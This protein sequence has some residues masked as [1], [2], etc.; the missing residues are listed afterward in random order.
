MQFK[1]QRGHHMSS[2]FKFDQYGRMQEEWE[3]PLDKADANADAENLW[4][5]SVR[6]SVEDIFNDSDNEECS[7]EDMALIGD[8]VDMQDPDDVGI[9]QKFQ[10]AGWEHVQYYGA[11]Q[12]YDQMLD[13]IAEIIETYNLETPLVALRRSCIS[14]S[15]VVMVY[16]ENGVQFHIDTR[17]HGDF[18]LRNFIEEIRAMGAQLG[19]AP[20]HYLSD[21]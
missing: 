20:D 14:N 1:L 18:E 9:V 2:G 10:E 13:W 7:D 17:K 8:N 15:V 5:L 12:T 11:S 19:S 6:D 21:L 3:D 16:E 4:G